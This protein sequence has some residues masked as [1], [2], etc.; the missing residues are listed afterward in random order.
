MRSFRAFAR[1]CGLFAGL[2]SGLCLAAPPVFAA[3]ATV[4][5]CETP[6]RVFYTDLGCANA[7]QVHL[8]APAGRV[9][10]LSAGERARVAEI[11]REIAR[12]RALLGQRARQT[13]T[14]KPATQPGTTCQRDPARELL[15]RM[16]E[17]GHK[18]SQLRARMRELKSK[19]PNSAPVCR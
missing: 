12:R 9:D 3:G 13:R 4:F 1:A 18:K 6:Q 11:D 10:P 19:S 14:R 7:R 16:A 2:L 8:Q 15:Q 17:G 5:R